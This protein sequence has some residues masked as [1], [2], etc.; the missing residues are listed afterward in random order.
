LITS[1]FKR[2]LAKWDLI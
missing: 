2:D 1:D